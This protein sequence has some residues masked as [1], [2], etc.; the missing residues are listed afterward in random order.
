MSIFKRLHPFILAFSLL[1]C[2]SN[3]YADE[4][5]PGGDLVPAYADEWTPLQQIRD[6]GTH[7]GGGVFAR[8]LE[9]ENVQILAARTRGTYPYILFDKIDSSGTIYQ[10]RRSL[11]HD[12]LIQEVRCFEGYDGDLWLIV[13]GIRVRYAIRFNQDGD[14][15]VGDGLYVVLMELGSYGNNFILTKH[16]D[17]GFIYIAGGRPV[18]YEP[19]DDTFARYRHYSDDFSTVLDSMAIEF[20]Q[21]IIGGYRGIRDIA[22]TV[23]N[24]TIHAILDVPFHLHNGVVSS[25]HFYTQFS[26]YGE[27]LLQPQLMTAEADSIADLQFEPAISPVIDNQGNISYLTAYVTFGPTA[28]YLTTRKTDGNFSGLVINERI[29]HFALALD[30]FNNVHV[31]FWNYQEPGAINYTRF[32]SGDLNTMLP[33]Q[34]LQTDNEQFH[35]VS[36]LTLLP[37]PTRPQ[38]DLIFL[39][40]DERE[41]DHYHGIYRMQLLPAHQDTNQL[42]TV[43]ATPIDNHLPVVEKNVELEIQ[44]TSYRIYDILGRYVR[45]YQDAG[46]LDKLNFNKSLETVL[47]T[48]WYFLVPETYPNSRPLSITIMK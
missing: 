5:H 34:S 41:P 29:G 2:Y 17:G 40:E 21:E 45:T 20:D 8:R 15:R 9:G 30:A 36:D 11:Q 24:D 25:R 10:S 44:P 26:L 4:D 18:P 31:A 42:E 22:G 37:H 38:V 32:H 14:Q 27:L 43:N 47:P 35:R 16:P 13:Q 19:G 39:G 33:I 6:I 1:V 3:I 46:N 12:I 7:W 48:G 28:I 23:K